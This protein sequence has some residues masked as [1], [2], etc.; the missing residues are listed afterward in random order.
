MGEY[1]DENV[2]TLLRQVSLSNGFNAWLNLE[3]IAA[4]QGKCEIALSVTD[5]MRQHHGFAH[6]GIV[7]T[8]ADIAT[9]WAAASIAGDVVT[10]SYSLQLMGAAKEDRIVAQGDVIK[11]G[12]KTVSVQGR[13]YTEDETG[14]RKLVAASLASITKLGGS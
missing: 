5:D 8:L 6:G 11:Q 9:S 1:S 7:G 14:K 3:L 2:E 13:V 4:G 10:S 12:P